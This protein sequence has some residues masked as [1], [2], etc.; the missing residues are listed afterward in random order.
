MPEQACC[1]GW[2]TGIQS[3]Y[4]NV[5]GQLY[6]AQPATSSVPGLDAGGAYGPTPWQ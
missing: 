2:Q 1:S 6:G 5:Q 3:A 4:S